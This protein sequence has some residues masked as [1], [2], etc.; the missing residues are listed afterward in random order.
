MKNNM[1]IETVLVTP[2]LAEEILN[3]NEDNR[4]LRASHVTALAKAMKR[5]EWKLTHQAIA[6][7]PEG[8]LLDGQHRLWAVIES[9]VSA[10][11]L[12][13]RNVPADTY[14]CLDIGKKRTISDVLGGN[15]RV[16][17]TC[18][19]IARLLT[20]Q[21]QVTPQQVEPFVRGPFGDAT[22]QL[23]TGVP[24]KS[25][26]LGS[27]AIRAAVVLRMFQGERQR[28]YVLAQYPAMIARNYSALSLSVQALVRQV[29][30][31]T[32]TDVGHEWEIT[33]R[34]WIAFDIERRELAKII[35][36]N[37]MFS[38]EEMRSVIHSVMSAAKRVSRVA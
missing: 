9:E 29:D 36:K 32:G 11:M 14:D 37:H 28:E 15:K 38:V 4:P 17:D 2:K 31:S 19:Y 22:E 21:Q 25:R 27:R 23:L 35:V 1:H 3:K 30:G 8:R 7:S 6:I 10:T 5:G 20:N 26:G 24:I 12:V 34:A 18:S 33:A 13:A 16:V